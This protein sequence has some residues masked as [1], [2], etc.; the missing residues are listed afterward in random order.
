MRKE[1]STL[2]I[3]DLVIPEKDCSQVEALIDF[4]IMV[5]SA[6]ME[7]T[8]EQWRELLSAEGFQII[9]IWPSQVGS[10]CIIEAEAI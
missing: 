6:G 10:L 3:Q 5:A 1:Y 8:E 4:G 7:R 9:K 2:L